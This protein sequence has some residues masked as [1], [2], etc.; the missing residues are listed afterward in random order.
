M[1]THQSSL[2]PLAPEAY[3]DPN[4]QLTGEEQKDLAA[5]EDANIVEPMEGVFS[6]RDLEWYSL[7]QFDSTSSSS[8]LAS[9]GTATGSNSIFNLTFGLEKYF[10]TQENW[11]KDASIQVFGVYS[12]KETSALE[13]SQSSLTNLEGGLGFNYHFMALQTVLDA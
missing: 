10:S 3:D 8:D 9:N 7:I 4:N 2:V 11:L 6:D 12:A 13:G 5:L 1:K